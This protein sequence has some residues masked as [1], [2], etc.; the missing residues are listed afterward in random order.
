VTPNAD[1]A[2]QTRFRADCLSFRGADGKRH[3]QTPGA[4]RGLD[5]GGWSTPPLGKR[6]GQLKLRAPGAAAG[7]SGTA[8]LYRLGRLNLI[9]FDLSPMPLLASPG[10]YAAWLHSPTDGNKLAIIHSGQTRGAELT[11][12]SALPSHPT[13][14][15]EL[16]IT[17]ERSDRPRKPSRT[18]LAG[19]FETP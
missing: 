2:I 6:V 10:V 1:G 9:W 3:T 5:F 11:I 17:T 13:R 18:V 4:G 15:R 14:F 19:A 12:Y 16:L 8:R 7:P